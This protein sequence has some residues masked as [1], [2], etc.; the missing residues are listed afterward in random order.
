MGR[1]LAIATH[2]DDETLGCGGTLLK[3]RN[4]GDELFWLIVTRAWKPKY[5]T[6]AIDQQMQQVRAVEAAYPFARTEW[7]EFETTC[8]DRIPLN[9]LVDRLRASLQ[10]VQP[11]VVYLPSPADAHSDHRVVFDAA[12]AVMKPFYMRSLGVRRIL[13]C[14]VPSE[15]DAGAPL[16]PNVFHPQ[17]FSDISDT[18]ERKL[19]IMKIFETELHPEPLPR[20]PSAIRAWARSR[21][22]TAGMEYAETFMLVRELV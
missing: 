1:V 16:V 10:K 15:T 8:L 13:A 4:Q 18:L 20:S 9:D 2:P 12:M 5:S 3:H 6:S 11:E 21:G 17:I 7:L 19:A 14:E 22:A